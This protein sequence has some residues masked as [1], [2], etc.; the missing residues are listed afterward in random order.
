MSRVI[1][2][3]GQPASGKSYSLRNL[4]PQTTVI[5]DADSKGALPWRGWKKGFSIDNKNFASVDDLVKINA[6]IKKIGRDEEYRHIKTLVIDGFN[7]AMTMAEV[8]NSDKSFAKWTELAQNVLLIAQIAKKQRSDL[9]IVFTAHVEVA[10]PNTAGAIDKIKTPGKQIERI[11][12]ESLFLYVFYAKSVDGKYIFETQPNRSSARTPEGLF[13]R[14]IPNDLAYII[15]QIEL[16]EE[17]E[18]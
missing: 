13:P 8:F 15:N 11:N 6:T 17:G 10:D 5:V 14:E 9:T 7:T 3:Y 2:I 1:L 18:I 16:Y 4:D 12:F